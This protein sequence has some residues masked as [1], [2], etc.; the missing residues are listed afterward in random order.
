M[1]R[2]EPRRTAV[3]GR[4]VLA[5]VALTAWIGLAGCGGG[6]EGGGG[7]ADGGRVSAPEVVILGIDGFDWNIVDPLV[8]QGRMPVFADL[9]A[10]G[11]RAD[12]LSLVP[13]EKS[14]VIWTTIAT[15]RLPEET[16]RGFLIS[17]TEEGGEAKPY[18]SWHRSTRAFWNIL[19][20]EGFRTAVLGW[21]E[22]WPAERIDGAIVSD[23]V[24]YDVAEREKTNRVRYRTHPELLYDEIEPFVFYP[25][26]VTLEQVLPLLGSGIDPATGV[27]D[28][29]RAG[30]RDIGWILA[31]DMTFTAI[32]VEFLRNRPEPVMAI[33]LRGPDAICHKFWGAREALESG[34]NGENTKLFGPAVDRYFEETDRLVGRILAEIDLERTNLF[35]VSDH[36]FQGGRR[37]LDGS[38]R[39]GIYMHRELGTALMVGPWAAG[40]GLRVAGARVQDVVPT[41]LHALDLPVGEDMDGEPALGLLGP[42]G[43][44]DREVRW[45]P[46]WETGE[47]PGLPEGLESP[48]ADQIEERIRALG[49]IE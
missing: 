3:I 29:F 26:D 45:V 14:P 33:Y 7:D 41:L 39:L 19:P 48:V 6:D 44:R 31:G 49:Y 46:T 42:A 28:R 40:E 2:T 25:G 47:R 38:V 17:S 34:G 20:G 32:G 18:T 8:E 30:V 35:I 4:L 1:R 27:P 24:K 37:A 11:A 9:L 10:R 13:L 12:L 5:R 15:G 23:Y 36:G 43:G 22:T 16:G 21:L